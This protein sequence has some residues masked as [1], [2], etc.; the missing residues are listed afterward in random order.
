[1]QLI[2]M[3]MRPG[4]ADL[5]VLVPPGVVFLEVKAPDGEQ[6]ERQVRF[7]ER[8]Q[9]MGYRYEVVRSVEDVACIFLHK[10]D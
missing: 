6:S 9:A 10:G 8:V 7:K 2:A 1:M 5:V 4:A 3:G